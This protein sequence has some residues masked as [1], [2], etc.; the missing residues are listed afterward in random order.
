V[1]RA[2]ASEEREDRLAGVVVAINAC[3]VLASRLRPSRRR[4]TDR[5]PLRRRECERR[6]VREAGGDSFTV[7]SN[8]GAQPPGC[9]PDA[10]GFGRADHVGE[11]D[12]LLGRMPTRRGT[13]TSR[14]SRRRGRAEKISLKPRSD[15][16][17][18]SA[19]R[20]CSPLQYTPLTAAIVGFA[21]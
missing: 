14:R 6:H 16:M 11:Q 13:P 7:I 2:R 5:V 12:E 10:F 4:T 1:K 15:A 19:E 21:S 3:A 17:I 8:C 9:Q 20:G 18:R